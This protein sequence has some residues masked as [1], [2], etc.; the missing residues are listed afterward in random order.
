MGTRV[1][2]IGWGG[3]GMGI[4][5]A[6]VGLVA[7][8]EDL[9]SAFRPAS[10]VSRLNA[11]ARTSAPYVKV[12]AATD[13]LLADN[14]IDRKEIEGIGVGA[15]NSNFFEGTIEYAHN[16]RWGHDKIVPF[17]DIFGKKMNIPG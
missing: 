11:A 1:D 14:N 5:N 3:D 8:H 7:R 4:V 9:W 15:P 13:R 17:T 10:E 16:I 2:L 12:S 6:L